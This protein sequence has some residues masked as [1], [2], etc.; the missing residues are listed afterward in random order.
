MELLIEKEMSIIQHLGRT[1]LKI[2]VGAT[3]ML[4]NPISAIPFRNS[5]HQI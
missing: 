5:M 4:V 1:G 3:C 2:D